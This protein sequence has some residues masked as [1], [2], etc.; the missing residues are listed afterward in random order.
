MSE[1]QLKIGTF[2]ESR[3]GKTCIIILFANETFNPSEES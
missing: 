2:G 3:V 1:I